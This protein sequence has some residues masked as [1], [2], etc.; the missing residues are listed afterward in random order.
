MKY[1][2]PALTACRRVQRPG[3]PA[4]HQSTPT[5]VVPTTPTTP[6]AQP[7]PL[8]E[9][10][11]VPRARAFAEAIR[12]QKASHTS[13][14]PPGHVNATDSVF[15][16]DRRTGFDR[17]A[18]R[19]CRRVRS[20]GYRGRVERHRR[21][22]SLGVSHGPGHTHSRRGGHANPAKA[23][24]DRSRERVGCGCPRRVGRRRVQRAAESGGCPGG[25]V[26]AAS[27]RMSLRR[28]RW[29]RAERE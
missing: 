17:L 11:T 7:G 8:A 20:G 15:S 18:G 3:R 25:Y 5:P 4:S 14:L 16:P 2:S 22:H 13:L 12:P 23:C 10:L 9:W 19:V 6:A 26:S 21:R 24:S 29:T 27:A 28:W 1:F